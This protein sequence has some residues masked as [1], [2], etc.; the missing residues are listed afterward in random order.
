MRNFYK[1]REVCDLLGVTTSELQ[2]LR[3]SG[4]LPYKKV[5]TRTIVYSKSDVDLLVERGYIEDEITRISNLIKESNLDDNLKFR[6]L[7]QIEDD[8]K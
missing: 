6:L 3:N 7:N 4:R 1:S 8:S 5:G 2:N